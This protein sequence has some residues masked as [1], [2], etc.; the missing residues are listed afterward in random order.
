MATAHPQVYGGSESGSQWI[1]Y[2]RHEMTTKVR[3]TRNLVPASL[4][5]AGSLIASSV[6]LVAFDSG[7][8]PTEGAPNVA[9][10]LYP[11][12][13]KNVI[14]LVGDGMGDSE[15][16]LA[17][18]YAYG[19]DGRLPGIDAMPFT[20]QY[21][22][23]SIYKDT[24]RKGKP[25]YVTDSAA[26]ATGFATG[27]KTNDGAIAV[28]INGNALPTILEIAKA[29]GLKTGNVTTAA[30]QDATPAAQMAHV[31]SRTCFGPSSS[32]CGNN[33]LKYGGLGSIT[34]QL[35][36][37]RP[38]L[39]F[40]GGSSTFSQKAV[41]GSWKGQ[42]LYA[43]AEQRG[44]QIVNSVSELTALDTASQEEP[45]IGLFASGTMHYTWHKV[46]A[47]V[48]GGNK[49]PVT[50]RDSTSKPAAE[51]ALPALT[52]KAI[53]LLDN[54][55][56]FFL[57]VEGAS[58]DKQD[59]A[60]SPCSQIGETVEFDKAVKVALDF[61]EADGNTLV[62]VVADHGHSSQIVSSTPPYTPSLALRTADGS[63]MR[64]AYGTAKYGGSQQHTGTQV[65]IGA[66]GPGAQ[67]VMGL[68]NQTDTFTTM[69]NA[70]GL[71]VDTASLSAGA[72]AELSATT[73]A[74]GESLTMSAAS[75]DGD[76]QL[77]V[78]LNGTAVARADVINGAAQITIVAPPAD[79]A[80]DYVI[81]GVQ[82]GVEKTATLTVGP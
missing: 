76:R 16:T 21:T 69:V 41:A 24:A 42:T 7:A 53:S 74:A 5:V 44:Y 34:E 60:A 33:A 65:R 45:V 52:T 48:G 70:L 2:R 10:S 66:Y 25:D 28:D 27:T 11:E 38:D 63:V 54:P 71:T 68:T 72:T 35:L 6:I 77:K 55:D 39:I 32:G 47:T 17:R 37:T 20:G 18:N 4:I 29:N 46:R 73:A 56:G 82:S 12:T 15:I 23:Y 3:R 19:A 14:L 61:A 13:A 58:I 36:D 49:T 31:N 75:F 80:Y 43:Q 51:Y 8:T 9:T 26:S 40:G 78:T 57:Q 59:H 64:V 62:L 81:T 22:T 67:H 79:G 30:I 50:C 1:R